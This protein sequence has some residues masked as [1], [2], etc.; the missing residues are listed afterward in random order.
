MRESGREGERE[1]GDDGGVRKKLEPG[2][3]AMH[4]FTSVRL[5]CVTS[6]VDYVIT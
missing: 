6:A 1:G 4:V 3:S 5:R 2:S